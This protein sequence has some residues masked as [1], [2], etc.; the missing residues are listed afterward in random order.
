MTRL[1]GWDCLWKRAADRPIVRPPCISRVN[2]EGTLSLCPPQITCGLTWTRTGV[3]TTRSEWLAAL[4]IPWW[5]VSNNLRPVTLYLCNVTFSVELAE[6]V[7]FSLINNVPRTGRS[8][9]DNGSLRGK[10]RGAGDCIT[11]FRSYSLGV[12]THTAINNLL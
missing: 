12:L 4:A 5:S 10:R 11:A 9:L 7:K 8:S 1:R 6:R 3:S 2:M